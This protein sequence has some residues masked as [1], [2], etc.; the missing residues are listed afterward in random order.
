MPA[1]GGDLVSFLFPT[2]RFAAATLHQGA[3][4][5]WNPSLYGGAPHV[6]DIQA[7]FLYPPNLL[8]FL[9]WPDFPYVALQW[10]SIGHIWFAG[11]G[12]YLLLAR[13]LRVRRVAALAGALAFMFSDAFLT[14]FGN[15]NFNAVASW[16]P[17]VFWAFAGSWKLEAGNWKLETDSQSSL[18][19]HY[20][21]PNLGRAALAGVLLAIAT[22]AGHIQATLF[23]VLA[24]VI[25][26][27]L[28]LWLNSRGTATRTPLS[29]AP[30][31]PCLPVSSFP[32][33]SP[34]PS[35]CRRSS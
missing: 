6:G 21:L 7:G 34:P 29:A 3:W 23:I 26:T 13:G 25:Y 1:D 22:L 28:W 30:L 31:F 11:A 9:L 12:M 10:L 33:S 5:L 15:L 17:W 16:L 27:G 14:H 19:T 20:S 24:L 32:S 8:L 18:V 4:P 35:S 2:Y